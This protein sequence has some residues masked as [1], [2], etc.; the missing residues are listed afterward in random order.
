MYIVVESS[1]LKEQLGKGMDATSKDM[2]ARCHLRKQ[3]VGNNHL[4][5]SRRQ[6]SFELRDPYHVSHFELV[7]FDKQVDQ[8]ISSPFLPMA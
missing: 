4:Q 8:L 5:A 2:Q 6:E 3:L 7:N 1:G